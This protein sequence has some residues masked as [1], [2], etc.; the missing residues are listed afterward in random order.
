MDAVLLVLCF[1]C[2]AFG[3]FECRL[4]DGSCCLLDVCSLQAAV[5]EQ[6]ARDEEA[7]SN[8]EA[9][10]AQEAREAANAAA[11]SATAARENAEVQR[12]QAVD[13]EAVAAAS[14]EAR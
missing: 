6:H 9:T 5:A 12:Q 10:A 2:C 7:R 13:A 3:A 1:W 8:A 4:I 14:A 11:D